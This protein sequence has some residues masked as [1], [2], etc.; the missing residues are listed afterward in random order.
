[1]TAQ[2]LQGVEFLGTSAVATRIGR[3][4]TRVMQLEREGRIPAIRTI[5]GRRV[6][7]ASDVDRYLEERRAQ[8]S[9]T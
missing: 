5:D 4:S 2:D 8:D 7:L 6:F 1:M 9:D 3:T